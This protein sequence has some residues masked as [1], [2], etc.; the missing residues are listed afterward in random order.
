MVYGG[1]GDQDSTLG[2]C[3]TLDPTTQQWSKTMSTDTVARVW[4]AC[5]QVPKHN[6]VVAFGGERDISTGATEKIAEL[7]TFDSSTCNAVYSWRLLLVTSWVLSP[8]LNL[9]YKPTTLGKAPS[10]R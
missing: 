1:S 9:W 4:H 5:A 2:D 6:L 10:G 3:F 7:M 8:D